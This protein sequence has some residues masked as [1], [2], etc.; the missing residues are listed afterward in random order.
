[1][2]ALEGQPKT[3]EDAVDRMQ[4]F[5]HSRPGRPPKPKRDVVRAVA[6]EEAL[7]GPGDVRPFRE[8]QDLQSCIRKLER[9]LQ[10]QPNPKIWI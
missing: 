3:V 1:M 5:Q 10:E 8:I 9:A 6:Q 4:F 7:P 2:Y